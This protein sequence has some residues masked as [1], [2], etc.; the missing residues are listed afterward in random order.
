MS[1]RC[2]AG[3]ALQAYSKY[4]GSVPDPFLHILSMCLL[5]WRISMLILSICLVGE[6]PWAGASGGWLKAGFARVWSKKSRVSKVMI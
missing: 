3:M 6:D 2:S 4:I 5:S 1:G